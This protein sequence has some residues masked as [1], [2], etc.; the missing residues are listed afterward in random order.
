[1]SEAIS[2]EK[3]FW[4]SGN[5]APTYE[6]VTETQL[7]VTGS[8]PPEL[9]GRYFRN[10][11]N[12][13]VGDTP[14]WFLGNGMIHGVELGNGKANWY[15]NRYVRTPLL[16]DIGAD[17]LDALDDRS[18][19]LANTHIIGHAGKI[20]ALEEA[21]WPFELSPELET[22]GAYDF[23]G[24]LDTGMTA[25]PKICPVTGELLFFAYGMAPPYMTYH[26]AS[27]SGE[28]LQ[29]EVIEVK[30]ATM[31]HDF[32]ITENY[33]IFMDLPLVWNFENAA[34]TGL[35]IQWSDEYGA[36]LGVMPRNGSNKDVVWYDIDPCY[37]YHPLNAYEEGDDIVID[38]CRMAHSMKPGVSEV[39]PVLHRW[40]IHQK[41][42]KVSESQLDDHAVE[43]PRV[44]DS[45]VGQKHRYGYTAEF[46]SGLPVAVAFRKYDL[47]TGSSTAHELPNSR[48]GGEPVFVP[49]AGATSEDDGYLLSFVYDP[50]SDQSEL[51]IVDASNM[52]ADPVARVHLPARVPAGFHGSWIADPA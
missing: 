7:Q 36:R 11:A 6:E 34:N 12:P 48:L 17:P 18:K 29:S 37:V 31:V 4:L 30:G 42:G 2:E 8:I 21:H 23:D 46:G 27:A 43:F 14:H 52:A 5:F 9:N 3:P 28:L 49:A 26:R 38:V 39:P 33:V 35:P 45:L 41:A 40:T 20:L 25:H 24:K 50:A 51:I 15:R 13:E 16:A 32:N 22:V 10:G 47:Q 1:M 19:S 44:P